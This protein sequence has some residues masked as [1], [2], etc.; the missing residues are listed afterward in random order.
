MP[1]NNRDAILVPNLGLIF[2]RG[3]RLVPNVGLI[4]GRD[5]R[6]V[7]N[8]GLIFGRDARLVQ[9]LSGWGRVLSSGTS[10]VVGDKSC[11]RGQVLSS[12]TSRARALGCPHVFV[13]DASLVP[14]LY[15]CDRVYGMI[16]I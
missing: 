15:M 14:R 11:R 1:G 5:A 3:A 16:S 4:F 2:G 7:P 9:V 6:L 13:R 10:L 8:L 12:G